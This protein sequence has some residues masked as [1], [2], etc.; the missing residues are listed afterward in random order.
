MPARRGNWKYRIP[1]GLA[2]VAVLV[3]V[4]WRYVDTLAGFDKTA[5]A[6]ASESSPSIHGAHGASASNG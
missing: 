6:G 2:I 5:A 4:A 1:V 3:L